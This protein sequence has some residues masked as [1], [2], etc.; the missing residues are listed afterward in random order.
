MDLLDCYMN[1]R[2]AAF[3][4]N[5]N[6]LDDIAVTNFTPDDHKQPGRPSL[7]LHD[8]RIY[9]CYDQNEDEQS[10]PSRSPSADDVRVYVKVYEVISTK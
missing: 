6:L 9:V 8:G 1:V 5:W 3:D 4:S 7:A 10:P 2:L